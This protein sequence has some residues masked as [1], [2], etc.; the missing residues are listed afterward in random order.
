MA[1]LQKWQGELP[2]LDF[3]KILFLFTKKQK[4]PSYEFL[5]YKYGCFSFHSYA[6]KRTMIK[7]EMIEDS[8]DN[9][10]T[11]DKNDYISMLTDEDRNNLDKLYFEIKNLK[12]KDLVKYVYKK[13]PYYAINSQMLNILSDDEKGDVIN[14]KPNIDSFELFTIGYEGRS[15]EAYFN[16]LIKNDIHVLCDIRKNSISM[17]YGFSKSQLSRIAEKM[18]IIYVHIP[19][20]GIDSSKRQDLKT[21]DDYRRL[22]TEYRQE[23]LPQQA[24]FLNIIYR[25]IKDNKRVALT[26]FEADYKSCH[27]SEVANAL[28]NLPKWNFLVSHI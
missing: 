12:G 3:Q 27:R 6:D 4:K 19:Q 5:P 11:I 2:S 9:W 13:Y 26:C 1:L 28:I 18:G 24:H 20:L 22:F 23:I 25:L 17:K 21:E 15:V 16:L 10:I 8:D 7:Y 14:E